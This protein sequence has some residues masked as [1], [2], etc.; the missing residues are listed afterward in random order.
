MRV[1]FLL[2]ESGGEASTVAD[3]ELP[4]VPRTGDMVQVRLPDGHSLQ[5]TVNNVLWDLRT[6]EAPVI[7]VW[8]L[9]DRPENGATGES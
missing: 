9:E 4:M 8:G 6:E 7:Y 3:M 1:L 2:T 5:L